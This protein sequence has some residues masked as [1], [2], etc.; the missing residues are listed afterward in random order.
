MNIR[1]KSE[2]LNFCLM[3][4]TGLHEYPLINFNINKIEVKMS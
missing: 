2:S 4:D 3:D 1:L